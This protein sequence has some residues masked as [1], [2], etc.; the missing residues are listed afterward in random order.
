V[1]LAFVDPE[2]RPEVARDL[3]IPASGAVLVEYGGGRE[4]LLRL[5]ETELTAALLRLL[6]R[7]ENWIVAVTGH[8]ER[9]FDGD[10]NHDLRD[11]GAALKR[12]GF[13]LHTLDLTGAAG[14]PD[15]TGVLIVADPRA[16]FLLGEKALV[17]DFLAQGGNLL[18]LADP[19]PTNTSSWLE[20]Q[21]PVNRLPGAVVDAR[22]A[23][24]GLDDPR[25]VAVGSYAAHPL[26]AHLRSLTL[27]PGVAALVLRAAS[28]DWRPSVLLSSSAASWN[29]TGKIRGEVTRDPQ[30][31]EVIGPLPLAVALERNGQRVLVVGDSDFMS[32]AYLG[33][34]GN[35]DLGLAMIRWLTANDALIEIPPPVAADARIELSRRSVAVLAAVFLIGIPLTMAATGILLHWRRRR[36]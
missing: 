34:G 31:G 17:A 12:E 33:N 35:L 32:N 22:G 19:D 23:G 2:E 14:I 1:T 11:F 18:W 5:G 21:L 30:A 29:E 9:R 28:D 24:L 25:H 4:L 26:T 10:A 13:R 6:L 15:N 3:G 36:R 16:D 8:G 20:G 27:F 7:G